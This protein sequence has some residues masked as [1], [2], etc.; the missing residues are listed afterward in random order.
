VKHLA[1]QGNGRYRRFQLMSH[2]VDEVILI[3]DN[4]LFQDDHDDK[5]KMAISSP[6]R[7]IVGCP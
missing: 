5:Y 4:L 3:V 7:I 6:V 1:G 2:V